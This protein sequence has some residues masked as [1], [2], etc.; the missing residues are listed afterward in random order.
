MIEKVPFR[1]IQISD[2]HLF[3]DAKRDLLGVKTEDSFQAVIDLLHQHEKHMDLI[4]LSGD[5]AQDNSHDAYV[6]V[7]QALE[8]FHVPV[9]CVPGN[10]DD[11]HTMAKVYP[12][13]TIS[14]ERHIVLKNWH[15]I[16]L[17]SQRHQ[18]VEGNFAES[19]L[20]YLQ[21][22]LQKYPEHHAIIVFHH[23]PVPVGSKWLDNLGLKNAKEFW[24]VVKQ[25]PKVHTVLFGHVHQEF[26]T[27]VEGIK[28]YAVPSTCIQFK[29]QDAFKLENLPPGYRWVDLYEDGKLVTG[30]RRAANYVGVYD[31]HAK[32]Y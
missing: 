23:Q 13:A 18:A 2:I 14:N 12:L 27:M 21:R 29:C 30:V 22:C 5:I 3:A 24:R 9:Y 11:P 19:E 17:N 7:A 32:G 4:L 20:I 25:Y 15:I 10:H 1:L 26:E 31:P 8:S 6:R 28:C 16:L